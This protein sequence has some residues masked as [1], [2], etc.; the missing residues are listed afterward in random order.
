MRVHR[1]G[2]KETHGCC[3]DA[4]VPLTPDRSSAAGRSLDK[5][6]GR[7]AVPTFAAL[8]SE[9]LFLL[10]DAVVVGHLGT[11]QLAALGLAGIVVQ[12]IVGMFVFLAYGTTAAVARAVGAGDESRAMRQGVDGIW[13]AVGIG[14]AATAVVASVASPLVG[15]FGPAADVREYAVTYLRIAAF[16]IPALLVALAA[17][18]VVRG[19]QD[20]RTPLVLTVA[21]N[22]VNIG[23][24]VVLVYGAGLGIAGSALG[25]LVAQTAGA[26]AL[27]VVVVRRARATRTTLAP[28]RRG[29]WAVAAGGLPLLVRTVCLRAALLLATYVAVGIGTDAVAAQQVASTLWTFLAFALDAI[30]IAGQ[31]ITGRLLGAGDG[32]GAMAAT[33][34]MVQWGVGAGVVAGLLLAAGRPL[35]VGWFTSDVAVQHLLLP[36]LLVAAVQQPVAG[37]VFVLDGVLI[38]AGDGRYL[39]WASLAT[40]AVFAT[41]AAVVQWTNGGVTTLWWAFTGFMVAR[42]V[43]LVARQLSGRWVVLG[44]QP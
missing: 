27:A 34:R 33:R 40:L 11:P 20:T 44:Q 17:T 14:L 42:L 28:H 5:E 43:T 18:G 35:I 25:T 15:A 9:P 39:A 3:Q 41:L 37:V 30:A 32:Q 24:N 10:A 4:D 21:A 38:G 22:L 23:L 31:A 2:A 26:A 8:V 29:L 19:M 13:L 12:T 16:G 6:I 7:L 1:M 36:V